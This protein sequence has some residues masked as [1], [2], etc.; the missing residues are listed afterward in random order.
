VR[1][2]VS[3]AEACGAGEGTDALAAAA[4]DEEEE[5]DE[6]LLETAGMYG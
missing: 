5:L 6:E 1:G 2:E 4:D 3:G